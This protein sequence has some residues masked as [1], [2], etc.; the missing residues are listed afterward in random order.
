M[1]IKIDG[2][3][4]LEKKLKDCYSMEAVKKTVK[5]NGKKLQENIQ[6]NADFTKCYQTGATKESVGL[7]I[8]D[9]GF[10]AESGATTEYAPYLEYGTRFMDAQPFIRPAFEEQSKQFQKDL[11]RLMK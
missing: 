11:Q 6:R 2:L 5:T 1:S 10:T 8:T 4:E 9:D 7:E 3:E